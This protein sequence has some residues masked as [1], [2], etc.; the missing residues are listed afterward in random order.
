MVYSL[1]KGLI[2]MEIFQRLRDGLATPLL[3]LSELDKPTE[4]LVDATCIDVQR[5]EGQENIQQFGRILVSITAQNEE[6][7][8]CEHRCLQN[9]G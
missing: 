3:N 1:C 9:T 7:C 6:V 4:S 5:L 8:K 2:N